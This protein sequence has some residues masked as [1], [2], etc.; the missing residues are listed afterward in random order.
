MTTETLRLAAHG[1][2]W[3]TSW[4]D[5]RGKRRWKR[6]GNVT[7]VDRTA[8]YKLFRGFYEKW[9]R[10]TVARGQGDGSD[11]TVRTLA[12]EYLLWADGYYRKPTGR[13]TGETANLRDAMNTAL[14]LFGDKPTSEVIPADLKACQTAMIDDGLAR[15]TINSRINRIRRVFRWGTENNFVRPEVWW[16]LKAVSSL[17]H[18]RTPAR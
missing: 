10:D 3:T 7:T 11:V 9:M 2:Y 12:E 5:G 18:G 4:Y 14:E 17:K 8:A 13:P 15:K 6:F 16:G 1:G